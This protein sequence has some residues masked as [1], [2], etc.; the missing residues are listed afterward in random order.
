MLFLI[1]FISIATFKLEE[2]KYFKTK[3]KNELIYK[4]KILKEK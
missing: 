4:E 1:F 2:K 3:L